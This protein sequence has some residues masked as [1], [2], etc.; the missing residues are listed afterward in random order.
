MNLGPSS[1]SS[2]S[3]DQNS[4]KR[5]RG[6]GADSQSF[7][8]VAYKPSRRYESCCVCNQL[9]AQ[10][11]T[12]DLYDN[13]L[14]N[15]IPSCSQYICYEVKGPGVSSTQGDEALWILDALF[16]L[17]FVSIKRISKKYNL[18]FGYIAKAP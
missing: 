9:E 10:R 2:Q 16:M 8:V 17:G 1:Q 11:E 13:H 4:G 3:A 6:K 5:S 15:Y 7:G 12:T 14:H 18:E